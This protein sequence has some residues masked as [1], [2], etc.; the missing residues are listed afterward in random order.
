MKL[1]IVRL[2]PTIV[3]TRDPQTLQRQHHH[4]QEQLM[5]SAHTDHHTR[6]EREH[7]RET[8]AGL[9]A[10]YQSITGSLLK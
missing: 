1:K 2:D 7:M 6:A 4:L 3:P 10:T 5:R 8:L 9:S